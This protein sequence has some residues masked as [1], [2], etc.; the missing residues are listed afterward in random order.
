MALHQKVLPLPHFT[1]E[2]KEAQRSGATL[3]DG[4]DGKCLEL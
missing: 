2:L 1:D 3:E 4:T